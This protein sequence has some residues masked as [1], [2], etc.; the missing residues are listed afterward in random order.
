MA[1]KQFCAAASVAILALAGPMT[2]PADAHHSFAMFD[3]TKTITVDA[4]VT[5]FDWIN[6]HT[7][8][9]ITA[10][11]ESGQEISWGLEG[12]GTGY[13]TNAGWKPD[14]IQPGARVVID[15]HPMKDGT[16]GGQLLTVTFPDGKEMCSGQGCN[17]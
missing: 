13:M 8:L 12:A 5:R 16:N 6:P 11:D 14:T 9:Y 15:F 7:W 10:M 3:N 2:I 4:T 17:N 1:R